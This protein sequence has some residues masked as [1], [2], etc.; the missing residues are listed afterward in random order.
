MQMGAAAH[1][2]IGRSIINVTATNASAA[3]NAEIA[4]STARTAVGQP[5]DPVSFGISGV[6]A[7]RGAEG[8][9]QDSTLKIVVVEKE[10][11]LRDHAAAWQDLADHAME[12]NAFYEPWMLMPAVK[13][14]GQGKSLRFIFIYETNPHDSAG[15]ARLLGFFPVELLSRFRDLPIRAVRLWQHLHCFLCTPLVRA[16]R[17]DETLGALLEWAATSARAAVVDF[18]VVGGDGPF[19]RLLIKHTDET[20]SLTRVTSSTT[21]ALWKRGEDLEVYLRHALSGGILKEYRRQRR[22][23]GEM[24][25]L[26]FSS[27]LQANGVDDWI[28]EFMRLEASGWKAREGTALQM[29]PDQGAYVREIVRNGFARGQVLLD[30]LFLDGQPVAMLLNF[31]AG[32]GIFAFKIAYD[33]AFAKYSPGVQ[34]MLDSLA[35]LHRDSR[36]A[37]IDSCAESDH[38]MVNRLLQDRRTIA[39]VLISTGIMA[40]DLLIAAYPAARWLSHLIGWKSNQTQSKGALCAPL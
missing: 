23:L 37:W 17:A 20:G 10:E 24:G 39:T 31:R 16:E 19:H 2:Y 1:S 38:S 30:G 3:A 8:F 32:A 34:V 29:N 7:A 36:F 12:S 18:S 14:L 26:E 35:H 5:L 21:R 28:V 25:R 6:A 9:A 13:T 33:E 22:R 40:G 11:E 27:V 15:A 4:Q